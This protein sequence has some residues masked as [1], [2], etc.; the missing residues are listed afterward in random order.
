MC[1]GKGAIYS[2]SSHLHFIGLEPVVDQTTEVC[3][4]WTVCDDRP[5]VTFL[6]AEWTSTDRYQITLVSNSGIRAQTI[7]PGD[8]HVSPTTIPRWVGGVA[9]W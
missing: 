4:A 8:E 5:T 9:Q 7:R 3:T 1:E 2:I 6:T